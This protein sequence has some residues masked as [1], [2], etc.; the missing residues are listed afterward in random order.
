MAAQPKSQSAMPRSA[1]EPDA[2]AVAKD[3]DGDAIEVM[4]PRDTA[5]ASAGLASAKPPQ[6]A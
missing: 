1:R 6:G 3:G 4:R 2:E 5:R